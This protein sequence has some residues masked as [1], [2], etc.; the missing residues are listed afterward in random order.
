MALAGA[1]HDDR[2]LLPGSQTSSRRLARPHT[3]VS[4]IPSSASACW[5]AATWG[6]PPST[7][8]SEGA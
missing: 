3:G 4:L 6:G 7:T 5:A 8:T 2:V 1:G